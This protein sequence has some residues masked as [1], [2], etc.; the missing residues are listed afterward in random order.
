[1]RYYPNLIQAVVNALQRVF[2]K[3][4]H[5]GTVVAQTLRTDSRWGS[6]DRRFIA[7]SIYEII[8]WYRLLYEVYGKPPQTEADWWQI[9]GIHQIL[10][11]ND[12]PDWK[13]FG[14]LSEGTIPEKVK[15]L[16]QVRKIKE[17][18]PDWLDDLGATELGE[19]KW[20][21][22][23]TALN[24]KAE[25]VLRVNTLKTNLKELQAGLKKEGIDTR[26]LGPDSLELNGRRKMT[27]IDAYRYG[28]FEIQDFGSQ[29]IAPFLEVEPGMT[30]IDACAGA[31]GKTLHLAALMENKGKLI[32]LDIHPEKLKELRTR[33]KR[34]GVKI[35]ETQKIDPDTLKNYAGQADRLLLDVPCSG[36]GVFKRKPDSKWKLTP[37]MLNTLRETQQ[38]ILEEYS[39]MLKRGG[40][41]VY[42]TCSVF[43]S[44][45][46]AQVQKFLA[47]HPE[48]FSLVR[49]KTISPEDGYDGFY[50]ALMIRI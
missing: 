6:R 22:I 4:E 48:Q 27:S 11:G 43:P 9:F 28:L 41:M 5:A 8:R 24:Q 26:E 29:G 12:L 45:N 35:V 37:E 44:E 25:V 50:M 18:I 30:V 14:G 13:E 40:M 34:N 39:R 31:G 2:Q 15:Q 49:E 19:E 21:H 33:A 10:E 3:A 47:S 42:A 32:A 17:S 16:K 20:S 38:Y 23:I 7:E 46:E 36:S 1:M